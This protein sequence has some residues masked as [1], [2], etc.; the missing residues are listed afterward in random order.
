M[1]VLERPQLRERLQAA[2]RGHRMVFV[3]APP[4]YGKTTAIADAL[5]GATQAVARYDA[6]PWDIQT[7]VEPLVSAVRAVRPDFGRRALALAEAGADPRRIGNAFAADLRHV[8]SETL[9][10]AEDAHLLGADFGAFI[11]GLFRD[12]PAT[13]TWIVSSRT[14]PHF[15]LADL[16][17]R[18]LVSVVSADELR[19]DREAIG[20]LAQQLAPDV[21]PHRLDE[22]A[23]RTEGWPAGVVLSLRTGSTPIAIADGQFEAAGAFLIEQLVRT[24]GGDELAALERFAVYE[25]IEDRLIAADESPA[26]R[27]T[28]NGLEGRGAMIVRLANGALRVHPMLRDVVVQ[29]MAQRSGTDSVSALHE[30]A[31]TYYAETGRIGAALFHIEASDSPR[32]IAAALQQLGTEAIVRGYGDQVARLAERLATSPLH[33]PALVAYLAGWRAKQLGSE[34]ARN[35]FAQAVRL[36]AVNGDGALAFAARIE[37]VE[38]DLGRGRSVSQAEIDELLASAAPLGIGAVSSVAIR[39]G[40]HAAIAGRFADALA[41]A[42]EA[43]AVKIPLLQQAAAPLRAYALTVLGRFD[44]AERELTA[45]IE[46][47]QDADSLGLRTRMLV[48][49]ARLALLRGDTRGACADALEARRTGA[50]L[51]APSELAA[52]YVALAEAAIHLGDAETGELAVAGVLES[53]AAAWYEHDRARFPAL[54]ALYRARS[55]FLRAG[56]AAALRSAEAQMPAAIPPVQRAMLLADA[57]WY[58]RLSSARP[59]ERFAAAAAAVASAVPFDA[60]DA[61]GLNAAAVLLAAFARSAGLGAG[62]P[63]ELGAFAALE[64]GLPDLERRGPRFE[65]LL[66]VARDRAEVRPAAGGPALE[67]RLTPREAEILE[68]LALGLTNKEIA[69]RL[70]LGTRTVETH[71]ARILGKLGVNSRSRAIAAHIRRSTDAPSGVGLL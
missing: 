25:V 17:L 42:D 1:A 66:V 40:W 44:E 61:A 5:A 47:L 22:L 16:L 4:G 62:A 54:A 31:A 68:L 63:A 56:P 55:V 11:D 34:D 30:R 3:Q 21:T 51:I 33:D 29:R 9:I 32:V 52:L 19:F 10:V 23:Q 53:S 59:N 65:T 8:D 13:V 14:P 45:L 28:L 41:S 48:W 57:V 27:D 18:D 6:A 69:Q 15:A 36:G 50:G 2:I 20:S 39:A 60:A 24:F 26:T 46:R 37:L 49:S 38:H 7:F 35:H 43:A 58:A 67:E 12:P 71:V 70:V 64:A